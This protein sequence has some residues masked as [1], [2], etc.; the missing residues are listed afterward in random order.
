MYDDVERLKQKKSGL[1][2]RTKK[3]LEPAMNCKRARELRT[4]A[5]LCDIV[6]VIKPPQRSVQPSSF[7][8]II[9]TQNFF[10]TLENKKPLAAA[11]DSFDVKNCCFAHFCGYFQHFFLIHQSV[12]RR[13]IPCSQTLT[14]DDC[15]FNASIQRFFFRM[16]NPSHRPGDALSLPFRRPPAAVDTPT[17]G[18]LM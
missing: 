16:A 6:A 18:D 12:E 7:E 17:P 14:T 4:F 2:I 5:P 10:R 11:V 15:V 13:G 3:E 1:L 9:H 8:F